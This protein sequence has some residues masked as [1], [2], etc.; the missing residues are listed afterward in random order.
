MGV[1]VIRVTP[2]VCRECE[3]RTGAL[4][5]SDARHVP[6][7]RWDPRALGRLLLGRRGEVPQ[8]HIH[9]R[10]SG[11]AGCW[12]GGQIGVGAGVRVG[13]DRVAVAVCRV[14]AVAVRGRSSHRV[15]SVIIRGSGQTRSPVADQHR[16]GHPPRGRWV[17]VVMVVVMMPR[18]LE[19]LILSLPFAFV[20]PVLEPDLHLRGGEFECAG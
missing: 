9:K 8:I 20:P 12:Q 19:A 16:D 17:V 13:V 6:R 14:T 18:H 5:G 15:G 10:V 11:G 7:G 1:R 2:H 4:P 3:Q